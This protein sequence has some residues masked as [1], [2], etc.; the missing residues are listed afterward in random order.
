MKRILAI[1]VCCICAAGAGAQTVKDK[2]QSMGEKTGVD[3]ALG[4]TP[5]TPE[6]VKDVA[7]SDM[8]EVQSSQLAAE[9]GGAATKK[10]AEQMVSD[11][12]K[13]TAEL[14]S[15]LKSANADVMPPQQMD[16]SHQKMLDK[17]KSLNGDAF[18]RRYRAD[19]VE[20][21]KTAVSLF[22]RYAKGGDNPA[23]KDWAGKIEPELNSHL[24]MAEALPH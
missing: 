14:T 21:H 17:L 4:V 15:V 24:Q 13:T 9:R 18:D 6:F 8:F 23:L 1:A 10:F 16:D 3:S 22:Q 5:S 7:I 11:H 19:Q 12:Q 2:A 20:A